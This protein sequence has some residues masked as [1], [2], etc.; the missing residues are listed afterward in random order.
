M[1]SIPVFMYHHVAPNPGDMITVTPDIFDSQMRSVKE[2]GYRTLSLD[3]TAAFISGAF[4]PKE[5]CAVITFDDGYLDNYIHAYPVLKKYGLN[6][7]VFLVTGWVDR[8][9]ETTGRPY[10]GLRSPCHA[11]AKRLIDAGEYAKAVMTWDMARQMQT[12]TAGRVEFASHTADHCDCAAVTPDELALQLRTSKE[13]IERELGRPCNHLCWPK[14]RYN[15]KA[16]ELASA[17]GYRAVFTT[18]HGVAKP[19]GDPMAVSRIPVK[20][21]PVWFRN[22]LFIYTNPLIAAVYARLKG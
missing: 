1:P 8:A 21:G 6:A 19:G 14:G 15:A 22:R 13:T 20:E 11:E 10:P 16:V 9:T 18:R 5:R 17:A 12:E 7:A 4:V 3:E 2:G